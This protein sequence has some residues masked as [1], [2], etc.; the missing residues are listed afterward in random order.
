[1]MVVKSDKLAR[2]HEVETEVMSF[3]PELPLMKPVA[4]TS[5]VERVT[6]E[7]R[8]AVLAGKLRPGQSFSITQLCTELGVSHIPVR[9]ALRRLES[10]GLVELRPSRS[11]VVTPINVEDLTE[12]YTLR[13]R[14]EADLIARS[15][16]LY[17]DDDLEVLNEALLAME[18][19]AADPQSDEFWAWHNKFHWQLLEPAAGA[20]TARILGPLWH[21][22]ERYIR[23]FYVEDNQ[24]LG[25]MGEHRELYEAAT[26]RSS[27][28]IGEV[29]ETHLHENFTMLKNGILELETRYTR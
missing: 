4:H 10:Q 23:L 27:R 26:G 20:W 24:I 17:T 11:G 16:P 21:A 7:L 9:E 5:M 8:H 28:G 1:M 29:L 19:E 6:R 14:I 25:A 15:A 22:A 3:P 2:Q 12:I 13:I 18:L